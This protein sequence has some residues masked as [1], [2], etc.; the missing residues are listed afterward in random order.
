MGEA[1]ESKEGKGK[2]TNSMRDAAGTRQTAQWFSFS[3][4]SNA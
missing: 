4:V 1:G 3:N 2:D